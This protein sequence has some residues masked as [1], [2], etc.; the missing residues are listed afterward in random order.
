LQQLNR[1]E[2]PVEVEQ[3]SCDNVIVRNPQ[4]LLMISRRQVSMALDRIACVSGGIVI[5]SAIA[6]AQAP[7]DPMPQRPTSRVIERT[8]PAGGVTPWRRVLTRSVSEGREVVV[9]TVEAPGMDGR[10]EPSEQIVTEITRPALDTTRTT[11]DLFA[12]GTRRQ[13]RL[14]ERTESTEI[15]SGAE[16]STVHDTWAPDLDGRLELTSRRIELTRTLGPDGRDR[17]STLL[18]PSINEALREVERTQVAERPLGPSVIRQESTRQAR[19]VNGRWRV[20]EMRSREVRGGGTEEHVEE[21]TVQRP[22]LSG[23]LAISERSIIRRTTANGREDVVIETYARNDER[24]V[25][26]GSRYGLSQRIRSTSTATADGGRSVVD[27][28]EARSPVA[29]SDPLRVIRRTVTTTRPL[30]AGRWTTERQVFE[31]DTN[32]RL[33]LVIAE[34]EEATG[35]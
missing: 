5:A 11:E 26:T 29:P 7:T 14:V 17:N 25:R 32:G 6:T 33:V 24:P 35:E 15:V 30:G 12:F 31:R 10:L 20:T 16:T 21:E 18:V 13:R 28:V 3:P 1:P 2:S 27:E 8:Y 22:D 4:T 34:T 19:D 23:I 9:E